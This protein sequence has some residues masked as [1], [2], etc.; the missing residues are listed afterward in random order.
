MSGK[1]SPVSSATAAIVA[2]ARQLDTIVESYRKLASEITELERELR[3][4]GVGGALSGQDRLADYAH[5]LM[6]KPG[7]SADKSVSELAA[8][9]WSEYL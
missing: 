9:A 1:S 3:K 5:A 7:I 8:S 2:K 6:V 4:A